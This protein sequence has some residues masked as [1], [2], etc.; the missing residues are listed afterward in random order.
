MA[1]VLDNVGKL[2]PAL[3]LPIRPEEVTRTET[4]RVAVHQ[5]LGREVSGW[6]DDFGPGL[7]TYA[8]SGHTGWRESAFSGFDGATAFDVLNQMVAHDFPKAKQNAID[9][10]T[11][12]ELVRLILI[13]AL[14]N[15]T[16][17]V[18][19]TQ[20]VLRR[21]KSRPLLYQYNIN[22][23]VISADIDAPPLILPN[24]GNPA[25][26]LQA[27][28]RAI[29]AIGSMDSFVSVTLR[30]V[31]S[32]LSPI[33]SIIGSFT[34]MANKVFS[35]AMDLIKGAKNIVS[36]IVNQVVGIAG[37]IAK[38]G[39]TVFRL[40]NTIMSL[41]D[42]MKSQVSRIGA[43]FNEVACIFSN[44]LRPKPVYEQFE[45]I[46]GASNCSST[47]GGTPPSIYSDANVFAM[48]APEKPAVIVSGNAL[49]SI[50][51]LKKMDPVLAPMSTP[52]VGRQL[53]FIV[54][55]VQS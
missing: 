26:G 50:A 45:G 42:F 19:P 34:K 27:L 38:I 21:S 8:L 2:S 39:T 40:I 28:A 33:T 36:G 46:Y 15:F 11:D 30:K 47:V 14:N 43:A 51:A 23:Q 9:A 54:S 29:T 41:G 37:D 7:P 13:D 31:G 53:G 48:A 25:N 20:F 35:T 17:S 1:F 3:T 6:V 49:A 5:S 12:P 55:G 10:G 16:G 32:F 24:Y 4:P 52:E 22:M 18:V 44:A